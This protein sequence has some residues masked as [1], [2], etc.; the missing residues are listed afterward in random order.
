MTNSK[1]LRELWEEIKEE[2]DAWPS[3]FRTPKAGTDPSW[4]TVRT[5]YPPEVRGGVSAGPPSQ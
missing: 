3:G 4:E 2:I 5:G 1:S